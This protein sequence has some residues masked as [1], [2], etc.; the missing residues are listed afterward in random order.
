MKIHTLLLNTITSAMDIVDNDTYDKIQEMIKDSK[1]INCKPNELLSKKLKLR[2][3]IFEN[4][5]EEKKQINKLI[6]INQKMQ[7]KKVPY[8]FVICPTMGCNLRCTYCFEGEGL[9]KKFD[10]LSDGQLATIF[11]YIKECSARYI[12]YYLHP[13]RIDK[14]ILFCMML[15]LLRYTD[16][17]FRLRSRQPWAW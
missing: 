14:S 15:C 7:D 2:G 10:L 9:H 4:V 8:R 16:I 6:T 13:I 17:P 5:E 3:Y 11:N 1:N 12:D